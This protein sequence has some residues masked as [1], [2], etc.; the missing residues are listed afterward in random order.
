MS[1]ISRVD[2]LIVGG[3]FGLSD[4][5]TNSATS[6]FTVG[7][8]VYVRNDVPNRMQSGPAGEHSWGVGL[9]AHEL[10]HSMQ[11]E[12]GGLFA[13]RYAS[14]S[15]AKGYYNNGFEAV[16]RDYAANVVDAIRA[17]GAGCGC[18]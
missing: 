16:A 9:L 3:M 6:G 11:W 12:Q 4:W 10:V 8:T 5:A 7:N 14:E 13:A 18:P 2:A 1:N 15:L 17:G